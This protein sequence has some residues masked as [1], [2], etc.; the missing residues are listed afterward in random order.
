M[1]NPH[2]AKGTR[3]ESAIVT[4]LRETG[5][6]AR[7]KVQAGA[8]DTGDISVEGVS[9]VLEAKDHRTHALAAWM[10]QAVAEAQAAGVRWGVVVVKRTR[11]GPGEGYA[12]VRLAD[13]AD[14]LKELRDREA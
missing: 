6:D 13:L 5:L 14:I 8:R 1:G 3:W 2:K 9:V 12:I 7:R 10:D 11:R 4:Y